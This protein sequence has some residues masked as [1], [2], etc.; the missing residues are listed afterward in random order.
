MHE[1]QDGMQIELM[2]C[3]PPEYRHKKWHYPMNQNRDWM[4]IIY[5]LIYP[6]YQKFY[7]KICGDRG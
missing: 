2:D 7:V 6:A 5:Q 3:W 4:Q 1:H